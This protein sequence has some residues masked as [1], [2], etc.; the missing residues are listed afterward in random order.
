MTL[1]GSSN[2]IVSVAA[3]RG[4]AKTLLAFDILTEGARKGLAGF[5]IKVK[6]PTRPQYYLIN[7]LRFE[8]PEQ[9]ARDIAESD[10]STINAPIRKFRWL[11]VPGLDHQG[12]DPEFG[13]YTYTIAPRYFG[14]DQRLRPLDP[15]MSLDVQVVLAPFETKS[16]KLGFTRGFTQSQAFA[17]H[18]GK[19]AP[20][21]PKGEE[22]L[23]DTSEIAGRS[24]DG[25]EFRFEDEYRWSGFTARKLIFEILDQVTQDKELELDIFAYDLNEPDI[26]KAVISIGSRCRIILDNAALHHDKDDPK[27]E[28][29]FEQAFVA[30]VGADHIKRGKFGRYQ[31]H[32]VFIVKKNGVA[33]RVLTGSTNLSVTGVYVNSNHI[34]IYENLEIANRYLDVFEESWNTKA[35]SAF[36]H[37]PLANAQH[38]F[39]QDVPSTKVTFAPHTEA[40]ARTILGEVVARIG[41]EVSGGGERAS[42]LFAV[43]ELDSDTPNPVYEVL[44][45]I[46]TEKSIFSFGIS[47]NPTGISLYKIGSP[48][49]VLVTGKP[50]KT[51]LPPPFE[52]IRYVGLG[53]QVHHKF[54]VCGFRGND[55]TVFCGSSNLALGGEQANGDNLLTIRDPDVVTVFAIEA[56]G[57]IDHFNF[58][59]GL[60]RAPA[61][62]DEAAANADRRE[63]AVQSEW[64]LSTSD[65]WVVKYFDPKDVHCKDR[66]LFAL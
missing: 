53:H 20:I 51:N 34:L 47:D 63:A 59:N 5:T 29:K 32:K 7:N 36:K 3:H 33:Q 12:L 25:K 39:D 10:N 27:P 31:H 52:Q 56:I 62:N 15:S 66:E 16:L 14:D 41:N 1:A 24:P 30:S 43:M 48:D 40:V 11:H 37:S 42:I 45:Q 13:L 55:P 44:N 6:P 61:A 46:H 21:R 58:L 18:F 54:V 64:F 9:H 17:R 26:M 28:D 22:L 38:T 35:S 4:D 50:G 23:F 19:S 8:R 57:L 2:H 49:G 65:G 60:E